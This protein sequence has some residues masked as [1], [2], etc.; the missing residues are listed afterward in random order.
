MLPEPETYRQLPRVSVNRQPYACCS[1][2]DRHADDFED[3][4]LTT[5]VIQPE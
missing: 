2:T 3:K 4:Q 5:P 1:A